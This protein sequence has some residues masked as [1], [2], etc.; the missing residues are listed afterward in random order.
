MTTL[1]YYLINTVN[2]AGQPIIKKNL[3]DTKKINYCR[4]P[5][6]DTAKIGQKK[7]FLVKSKTFRT[8]VK[9]KMELPL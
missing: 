5:V 7:K 8:G 2:L 1:K 3:T 9:L 6:N 4:N